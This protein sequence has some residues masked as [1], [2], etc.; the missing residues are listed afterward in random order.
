[1]KRTIV[2]LVSLLMISV[3]AGLYSNID[4]AIREAAVYEFSGGSETFVEKNSMFKSVVI[5]DQVEGVEWCDEYYKGEVTV[6]GEVVYF[7][8]CIDINSRYD[9]DVAISERHAND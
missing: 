5:T 3:Q 8:A 4:A 7:D 2:F 9:I 1:M 6:K